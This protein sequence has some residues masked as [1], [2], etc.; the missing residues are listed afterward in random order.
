[1]LANE[2]QP[3]CVWEWLLR[4]RR[5]FLLA[6]GPPLASLKGSDTAG[7]LKAEILRLCFG[8]L[9]LGRSSAAARSRSSAGWFGPISQD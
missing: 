6:L 3:C 9:G 2:P 5:L 1:M 7:R 8:A 4:G